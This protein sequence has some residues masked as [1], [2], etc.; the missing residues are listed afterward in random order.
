MNQQEQKWLVLLYSLIEL[1]G[2]ST[3]KQVLRHIQEQSYWYRNDQNDDSRTSR[4][5]KVWRNDFSYER[6]HL[7]EREYMKKGT[8]GTWSIT[9]SGRNCF[10]SLAEKAK[11]LEPNDASCF[12]ASFFQKLFNVQIYPEIVADQ[13]L[14]EQL[15]NSNNAVESLLVPSSDGPLP[16]GPVSNR[17][18]NKN[19][20][21]RYPSISRLALSKA[22]Y[23][24]EANIEHSSFLSR[25]TSEQYM[26]P[27][28][29]I[30]M[31][32]TDYFNVSLDREQNIFS[33]CSNCHN[34]IHYGTKEDVQK[35][36]AQLFSARK[37]EICSVLGRAITLEEIYKIYFVL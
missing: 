11:Q 13:L 21:L 32:M 15:S 29:L 14:L 34:Q 20:Y 36:I 22:G 2:G 8:H 31:S 9:E 30:P 5:E 6:L 27:H 3:R 1:D 33:L 16:K 28:H 24:C 12:T 7:V 17:T 23:Q 37:N 35:L 10:Y 18:G 25:R 19:T 4:H 26:E